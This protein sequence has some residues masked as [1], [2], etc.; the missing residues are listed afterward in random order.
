MAQNS[1]AMKR[2]RQNEKRRI[3]NRIHRGRVRTVIHQFHELM[4]NNE[5]EKAQELLPIAYRVIDRTSRRGIIHP[6]AAARYKS[7]LARKLARALH[8]AGM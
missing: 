5:L 7:R 8:A 3:R 1:S 2:L 4:S 6:T